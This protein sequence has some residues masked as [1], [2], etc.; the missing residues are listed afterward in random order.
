[1]EY[2]VEHLFYFG[3]RSL[4]RLL[5]EAGFERPLFAGNRK[6]LSLDIS[7]TTSNASLCLY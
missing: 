4:E 1:M 3:R 2:K 7:T 6:V 5:K